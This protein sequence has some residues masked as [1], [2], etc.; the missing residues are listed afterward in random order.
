MRTNR[1]LLAFAACCIA[2]G[3]SKLRAD[4]VHPRAPAVTVSQSDSYLLQS[5][6]TGRK[7]RISVALP[8]G[9]PARASVVYLLD[10]DELF[11]LATDTARLL[12]D[13]GEIPPVLVVGIG[14][15]I[16]SFDEAMVPR[17]RDFTPVTDG[18][19]EQLVRELRGGK[20]CVPTGGAKDFLEFIRGELKPFIAGHYSVD[21][22]DSTVIGHSLGGLFALYALLQEPG[23]FQRYVVGSPCLIC[24]NRFLFNR[25]SGYA[26]A[27]A[28]LAARV[29]MDVGTEEADLRK[30]LDVPPDMHDA[31]R[32][33]LEA[34]GNP[35]SVEV[36]RQFVSALQGRHY[37][38]L[39][40]R[41]AVE[42]AE[43][44]E[45]LPP[46]LVSRG[47]RA[48]YSGTR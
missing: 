21:P 1:W 15:P 35:D 2:L 24:G 25:E 40:L 9:P 4:P 41:S 39:Q 3:V 26:A 7:Y 36:F 32:R 44:H 27:H 38:S 12:Q 10:A 22:G 5:K 20:C 46:I 47:L 31:E 8:L 37:A 11:G 30:I 48:V 16:H 43:G 34:T 28:D 29:Y 17:S 23:T 42:S 6:V 14:Y 13:S 18:P 45:S 33:Y 19:Y